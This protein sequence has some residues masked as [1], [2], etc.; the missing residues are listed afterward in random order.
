MKRTEY[1]AMS[2][3]VDWMF[4]P[5]D[6]RG[7][8]LADDAGGW[9]RFTYREIATASGQVAAE[10]R[11]AGVQTGDVVCL[12]VPTTYDSLISLFG[13]WL[14]GATICPLPEPSF[15]SDQDYIDHIGEVLRRAEPAVIVTS[16]E[17]APVMGK[18]MAQAGLPGS[19]MVVNSQAAGVAEL[20]APPDRLAEIALLQFTSGSTGNPQGVRVSWDNLAANFAVLRRWTDWRD[21]EGGASWLPLY[22]DMGLIGCLLPAVATQSDLWLMRPLQF[23]RDPGRWLSCFGGGKARHAA[24]PSFAFAY[25][26]RRITPGRLVNFDLSAWRSVIV[27][28]EVVDPLALAAFARFAAPTGFAPTAF[29]PAYGLAENTLGVSSPGSGHEMLLVRPDWASMQVGEPVQVLERAR[30]STD[31]A[32]HE[33]NATGWLVGHGSPGPDD[34]IAVQVIDEDGAP[35]PAGHLGEITV[36]GSSVAL[37]YHGQHPDR[38]TRFADG[39]LRTGDAGFF[40]AGELFVVGRMGD[41]LKLRGRNIYVEDLDAKVAEAA[42]LNRDRVAVVSSMHEGRAGLVVFAEARPGPWTEKVTERLRGEL[43][44]EPHI[45]IVTGRRGMIRRTSS[46]KPRRRQMWQLFSTGGLKAV[47]V[48]D[49]AAE[50]G[51]GSMS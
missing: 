7:F 13:V 37:G 26:A 35:L 3:F 39:V 24:S 42:Q 33:T 41:S 29:V 12:T 28:A 51:S 10:Y 4:T 23:I 32:T 17:I 1:Q 46:G 27:G 40:H 15:Q 43:G 36:T 6:D 50:H 22:H 45:T 5:R 30:F 34:G 18:A 38:T 9:Q 48:I 31:W 25:L 11:A 44:P 2:M 20:P 19:P 21:G 8:Y 16:A 14:A 47:V 49:T